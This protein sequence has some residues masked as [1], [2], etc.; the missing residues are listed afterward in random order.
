ME[1]EENAAAQ[2][3][4]PAGLSQSSSPAKGMQHVF[5]P[6]QPVKHANLSAA[7]SALYST[8][9]CMHTGF[10]SCHAYKLGPS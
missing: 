6:L 7:S 8:V 1:A 3:D 9:P 4:F 2:E 5:K 10:L